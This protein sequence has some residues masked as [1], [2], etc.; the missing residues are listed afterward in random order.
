MEKKDGNLHISFVT[1]LNS[2]V[3]EQINI[4]MLMLN[5]VTNPNNTAVSYHSLAGPLYGRK[6]IDLF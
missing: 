1:A 4:V 6:K 2:A 3:E 5:T